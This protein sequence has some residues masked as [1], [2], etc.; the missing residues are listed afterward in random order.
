MATL[1]AAVLVVTLPKC[2]RSNVR[3]MRDSSSLEERYS[4]KQGLSLAFKIFG[5]EVVIT[6]M[7]FSHSTVV[8]KTSSLMHA[9][10]L[11]K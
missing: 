8:S 2:Q 6:V 10:I 4:L 11:Y 7:R 9:A 1:K 3:H 5:V